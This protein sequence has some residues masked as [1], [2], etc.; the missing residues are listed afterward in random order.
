MKIG[1]RCIQRF[2]KKKHKKIS[3]TLFINYLKNIQG[4][5]EHKIYL[6]QS[7]WMLLEHSENFISFD[8]N[9]NSGKKHLVYLIHQIHDFP[10]SI[11][12][13]QLGIF[14]MYFSLSFG[15]V[16]VG[17]SLDSWISEVVV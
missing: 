13:S 15:G 8:E 3:S 16:S 7:W 17:T 11:M 5:Y 12:L 2:S 9:G 14:D 10:L 6:F 4:Y 1:C